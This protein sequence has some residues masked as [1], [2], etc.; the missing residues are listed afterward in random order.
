MLPANYSSR[1]GG[2]AGSAACG[3]CVRLSAPDGG[4]GRNAPSC[5]ALVASCLAGSGRR[6]VVNAVT[7][8]GPLTMGWLRVCAAFAVTRVVERG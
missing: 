6:P 5:T 1:R 3:G 8:P 4:S 7:D 2:G